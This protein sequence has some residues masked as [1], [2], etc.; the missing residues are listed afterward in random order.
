[1]VHSVEEVRGCLPA[2]ASESDG[3]GFK[4]WL[5]HV[6][7]M[8]LG[9]VTELLRAVDFSSSQRCSLGR[10]ERAQVSTETERRLGVGGGG[11]GQC[12]CEIFQGY[13]ASFWGD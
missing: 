8:W 13:Q 9:R 2:Q 7:S 6:L 1:M 3:L 10:S 5:S 12:V 4:S 11:E